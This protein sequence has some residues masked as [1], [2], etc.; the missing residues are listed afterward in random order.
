MDKLS[1]HHHDD[2]GEILRDLFS[3]SPP[4]SNYICNWSKKKKYIFVE[5]AKVACH[6]IKYTLQCAEKEKVIIYDDPSHVH[7]KKF[8]PLLSPLDDIKNFILALNDDSYL[9]FCFVR[10]PFSRILSCYLDK[11]VNNEFERRRLSPY[12]GLSPTQRPTFETFLSVISEQDDHDRDIHWASQTFLLQPKKIKYNVVGRFENFNAEFSEICRRL[13]IEK[14]F[15]APPTH[16][17]TNASGKLSE[18]Y[19]DAAR[20]IVRGVYSE[21]FR[22]FN[23]DS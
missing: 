1:M 21:D 9:K 12:L 13:G 19:T 5:T 6:Q 7:E 23:Y 17:S 15:V 2:P 8:S 4:L 10:N 11:F 3:Q 22:N 16:Y 20:D 14:Y 18:Y